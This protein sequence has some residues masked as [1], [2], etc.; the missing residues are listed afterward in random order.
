MAQTFAFRWHR[1]ALTAVAMAALA[2]CGDSDDDHKPG[3]S[4]SAN[5]AQACAQLAGKT[6]A[7]ATVTAAATVAAN[8]PQPLFC[9]VNA[10]IAPKLN[11]ELRLPDRWNGKLYYG[12]GGGYNGS[13]PGIDVPTN[14]TALKQG[15]ATV[16]SDSGHSGNVLSADFA[17]DD[18]HA[19]ALFGHQSVPTVMSSA[20]QMLQTAYGKAPERSYFEGCSNGGREALMA[21][22]RNPDLF[23]GI[24]ARAPAYNW[25][26]FMGAFNRNAKA[27]AAPGG[28]VNA[29]KINLLA[30]AV[31]D[32]C[33]AQDGIA[34]GVVS[35]PQSCSFDPAV[36]RCSGG[37]DAGD[38][39]L[40]DAQLAAVQS[41]TSPAVWANGAYS[42]AGWALSGN[43]DDPG[44]WSA[45]LTGNGNVNMALQFLFQDTTVKNYLARDRSQNS[46]AYTWDSN[47]A[48]L[49][50]LSNLNDA[51][52]TDLRPLKNSNAKLILWHGTND[53][54]LSFKATNAYYEGMVAAVGGQASADEFVR[55]Y[56]APGVNHCAGGPGADQTDLLAALDSWVTKGDAPGT[57]TATKENNGANAFSRPLC[58]YPQYPRYTGPANDAAAAA[59]ASNYTCTAP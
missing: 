27:L 35:N 30:K 17:L 39:C 45:W 24:I 49:A 19:A 3:P 4:A 5:A 16:N 15:Y 52:N 36:L 7:G 10:T 37:T 33:D 50:N 34:D 23:D 38:A 1:I 6:I 12:G 20:R 43:E 46:L 21:A 8:G 31:R 26:G 57:L 42:N 11:L 54:A 44:A 2:A 28:M 14:L 48:A 29:A 32:A 56:L 58:R 47:V 18:P 59:Q 55:Y 53:A 9:K 22:Q 41:W 40:S 25:V 51:T 13:I